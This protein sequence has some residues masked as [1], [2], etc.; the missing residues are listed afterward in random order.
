MLCVACNGSC[1]DECKN[2]G[3]VDILTCP[4]EV[5][6][7]DVWDLLDHAELYLEHG[8]PVVAGGQLDQAAG[9]IEACRFISSERRFWKNKLGI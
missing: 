6:T 9:F 4:L 7:Q 5:V 1:C 8:L 2:T 3:T